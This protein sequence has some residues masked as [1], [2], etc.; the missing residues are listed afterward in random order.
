MNR[1]LILA[2]F[3]VGFDESY[4]Q[5]VD[6]QAE[7]EAFKKQTLQEYNDFR[8]R[9]NKEYADFMRK[10]WE[11]YKGVKPTPLPKEE[12]LPPVIIEEEEKNKEK[13]DKPVIIEEVIDIPKPSPQPKPISPIEE[14]LVPISKTFD[15]TT[16]GT[17]FS[18]RLSNEHKFQHRNFHLA[19]MCA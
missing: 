13:E 2:L 11:E 16:Y 9:V 17:N 5:I 7:Y 1:L 4:A 18:V 8:S 3:I 12:E 15:F 6:L 14:Q 19:N 10:S